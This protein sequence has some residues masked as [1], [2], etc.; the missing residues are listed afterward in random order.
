MLQNNNRWQ[1]AA[2]D[3]EHVLLHL[4]QLSLPFRGIHDVGDKCVAVVEQLVPDVAKQIIA[5]QRVFHCNAQGM[6]WIAYDEDD[7]LKH[8]LDCK[9]QRTPFMFC[10][11]CCKHLCVFE[12]MLLQ[13][14]V[15]RQWL[16]TSLKRRAKTL[17]ETVKLPNG[18]QRV[19]FFKFVNARLVQT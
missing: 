19:I 17:D 12:N 2:R 1:I 11:V 6:S 4:L 18:Y 14:K 3:S 13:R 5:M 9:E 16:T 8:L 7:I 10:A 15:R